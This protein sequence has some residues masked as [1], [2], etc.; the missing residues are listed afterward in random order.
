MP[1]AEYRPVERVA[2]T[3]EETAK[4]LS[5]S[6][7]TAY[8]LVR[9]ADFPSVRVGGRWIVPVAALEQWLAKEAAQKGANPQ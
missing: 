3:V 9:R 4:A 5:I 1:K 6:R 7:N 2:L 8:A